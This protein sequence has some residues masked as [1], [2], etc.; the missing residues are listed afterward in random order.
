[1]NGNV[2]HGS[3]PAL[4]VMKDDKER[5]ELRRAR[6]KNSSREYDKRMKEKPLRGRSGGE[7]GGRVDVK[8][9][10]SGYGSVGTRC[11]G[12]EILHACP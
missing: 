1:M 6:S 12:C 2:R 8:C 5:Q 3:S 10:D 9:G 11:G 7:V 4:H